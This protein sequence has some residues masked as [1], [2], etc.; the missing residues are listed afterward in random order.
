[1]SLLFG[2]V[3]NWR[4]FF[5]WEGTIGCFSFPNANKIC[6]FRFLIIENIIDFYSEEGPNE[7]GGE[8]GQG[9]GQVQQVP[10]L[11]REQATEG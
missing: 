2:R 5:A 9:H 8:R 11:R 3:V 6:H 1:M 4:R 10:V 7:T